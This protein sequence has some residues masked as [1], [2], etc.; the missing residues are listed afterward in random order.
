MGLVGLLSL[1]VGQSYAQDSYNRFQINFAPRTMEI[2]DIKWNKDDNERGWEDAKL[3]S[4]G[5]GV[6]LIHGIGLSNTLPIFLETGANATFHIKSY[7]ESED[8]YYSVTS[9]Y[10]FLDLSIPIEAVYRIQLNDK[11]SFDPHFG[12]NLKFNILGLE[13][14]EIENWKNTVEYKVRFFGDSEYDG[15]EEK[16]DHYFGEG[17][18]YKAKRFQ[19]G[20]NVGVAV[21]LG[22]VRLGWAFQPDLSKY[23]LTND[24]YSDKD[25]D[26]KTRCQI[27]SVG[28]TF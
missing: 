9:S 18:K 5:F 11:I 7:D 2:K 19:F 14:G 22:G 1:S 15:D 20:L 24:E 8:K 27:L 12:F 16:G 3:K 23:A 21:N 17:D 25:K 10:L 28:F 13:K 4:P 6:G 26:V